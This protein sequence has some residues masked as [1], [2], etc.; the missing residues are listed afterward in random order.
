MTYK[1]IDEQRSMH[2]VTA[3]CHAL[4]IKRG[5]Y[6]AYRN[7]G[8]SERAKADAELVPKIRAVVIEH[9]F[10]YGAGRIVDKLREA[11]TVCSRRRVG[12]LMQEYSMVARARRLFKKTTQVD[13]SK[14]IAPDLIMRRF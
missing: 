10:R 2:S 11:G 9:K 13:D 6:N 12:H 5:T 14:R 1:F 7:R 4:D 8:T 3:L